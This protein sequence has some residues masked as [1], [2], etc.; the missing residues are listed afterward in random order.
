MHVH[1]VDVSAARTP[2]PHSHI[3]L[4][5]AD[6]WAGCA[7]IEIDPRTVRNHPLS[8]SPLSLARPISVGGARNT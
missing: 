1:G 7:T 4:D 3:H 2:R 8:R 5:H 6:F